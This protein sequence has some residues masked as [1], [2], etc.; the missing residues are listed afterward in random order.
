M[1]LFPPLT[2]LIVELYKYVR[3]RVEASE[4]ITLA[5]SG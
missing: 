3:Q 4:N 1:V 2:A 5:N